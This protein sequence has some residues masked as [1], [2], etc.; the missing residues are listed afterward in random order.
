LL[1]PVTAAQ[2]VMQLQAGYELTV[3][4][5]VGIVGSFGA[6]SLLGAW[7]AA[8]VLRGVGEPRR[9]RRTP[10]PHASVAPA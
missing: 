7:V 4:R 10:S 2:T 1:A 3:G 9:R 8:I 6:I 5:V